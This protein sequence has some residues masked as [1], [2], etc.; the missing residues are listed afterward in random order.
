[1]PFKINL[2]LELNSI[3][4]IPDSERHGKASDLF[5]PW[6]GANVSVLAISYGAYFLGFGIN[7]WQATIAAFIGTVLSFLLVGVSS[8]AGKKSSVP[9][10]IRSRATFGIKGNLLPG[11]LTYLVFVGWE[12]VLVSVATLATGTIFDRLGGLGRD[13]SLSLGFFTAVSLTIRGGVLGYKGIMQMQKWISLITLIAT[14]LYM[15][16]TLN[17]INW[18][19]L[20]ATKAGSFAAMVGAIIFG[21]TG[22]GLGWVNAAADYSRYLPRNVS[23]G[24][25]VSWTVFG[26]SLAPIIMV[27][28]GAALAG[29]SKELADGVS[30]DPVGALTNLLPTWFLFF[31]AF[32]AI[33]G[34]IGGAILDL[35]SSGLALVSIGV[36]IKRHFAA[37]IDAIIMLLGTIY[38]VWISDNFLLPFQ[39]FLITIGVPLA[40]WS[41]IF[42]ADV[43]LR[44]EVKEVD[45][46]KDLGSYR[47]INWGAISIMATGTFIGYGFVTNTFAT[48]LNWQGYL[49]DAI[50]GKEGQWAY[51]NIGVI[52][53]LLIGFLGRSVLNSARS[54]SK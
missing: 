39:G 24:K 46:Y 27:I 28:Y 30:Q 15:A 6:C 8:L 13:A 5:W 48:W 20:N 34:L 42:V 44:K 3:Q 51:A 2:E 1:M 12:T 17:T 25:V 21:M 37:S 7:F 49:M 54:E 14:G 26:A 33:F 11:F 40:A 32:I 36:P 22:I 50:G 45:L 16:L 47:G 29:S 38:I 23:S 31:F 35:Y 18:E 43:L 53:A 4:P 10:M 41:G 52:F 9:T 19:T